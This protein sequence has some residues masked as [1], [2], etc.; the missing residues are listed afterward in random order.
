MMLSEPSPRLTFSLFLRKDN[1]CL[2]LVD[3]VPKT[4]KTLPC[5]EAV[6]V[7]QN[8]MPLYDKDRS[9]VIPV[10]NPEQNHMPPDSSSTESLEV[11]DTRK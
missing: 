3:A 8:Q 7:E 5:K 1:L 9:F 6:T 10:R 4:V 2:H 11:S